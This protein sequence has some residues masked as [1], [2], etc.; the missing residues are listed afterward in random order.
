MTRQTPDPSD[1]GPLE[2]EDDID[3]ET[4]PAEPIDDHEADEQP[5]DARALPPDE[6][7]S[8]AEQAD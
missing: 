5:D 3:D 6:G 1:P 2:P 8:L 4:E 7:D